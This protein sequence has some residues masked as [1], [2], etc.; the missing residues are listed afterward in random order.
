MEAWRCGGGMMA[1]LRGGGGLVGAERM[2]TGDSD[3]RELVMLGRV[4]RLTGGAGGVLV[5]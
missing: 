1:V 2:S 4:L 5:D 3:R